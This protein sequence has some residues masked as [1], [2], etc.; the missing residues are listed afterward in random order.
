[1]RSSPPYIHQ[2]TVCPRAS[3]STCSQ[4]PDDPRVVAA[5]EPTV[6]VSA[7]QAAMQT[8][9]AAR[10]AST[11]GGRRLFIA[12]FDPPSTRT[13]HGPREVLAGRRSEGRREAGRVAAV[14]SAKRPR[15]RGISVTERSVRRRAHRLEDH[16]GMPTASRCGSDAIV[17]GH[18]RG[19]ARWS[20]SWRS[21]RSASGRSPRTWRDDRRGDAGTRAPAARLAAR[22]SA[23][24][25]P[26]G[27][28]RSSTL[29]A[30][31]ERCATG[32]A[33]CPARAGPPRKPR[34]RR[35]VEPHRDQLEIGHRPDAG[36]EG[37]P[38]AQC[39][40]SD[41]AP[42]HAVDGAPGAAGSQCMAFVR[43][44]MR[45][46]DT[47]VWSA[48]CARTE[49][50]LPRIGRPLLVTRVSVERPELRRQ[51]LRQRHE[52]RAGNARQEPARDGAE[53]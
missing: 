40:R 29:C 52:A 14:A 7:P 13:V 12:E 22:S 17:A 49:A 4:P 38:T 41:A 45:F 11:T 18:D 53:R 8:T 19:R 3:D 51:R 32:R 21:A 34:P 9:V 15:L 46:G 24:P 37:Q 10:S 2:R 35:T 31:P 27:R 39:R 48:P 25:R 42:Q 1:M 20:R 43:K 30:R 5:P 23:S 47:S 16:R 33:L 6:A 26:A 50:L 28:G 44:P 36:S